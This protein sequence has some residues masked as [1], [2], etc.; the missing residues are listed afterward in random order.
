[1]IDERYRGKPFLR[2]LE[3]FVLRAIG[4]L[5]ATDA[6][7]LS[8][9]TPKLRALYQKTGEWHEVVAAVMELPGAVEARIRDVW[10]SNSSLAR[11]RGDVLGPED[12]AR[13]F[14]DANFPTM[15]ES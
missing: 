6:E 12:F 4:H 3:C 11:D 1:M 10:M 9:M 15:V 7:A 14:V 13:M 2:L 5:S 8:A